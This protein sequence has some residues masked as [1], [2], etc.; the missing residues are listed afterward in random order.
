MIR[1]RRKR[2]SAANIYRSCIRHGNCPPDVKNKIENNT[3]ADKILRYGSGAVYF[4]SLGIGT[5]AATAGV[6]IGAGAAGTFRPTGPIDAVGPSDVIPVDV[7]RPGPVAPAEPGL[8]APTDPSVFEPV[9]SNEIEL[10]DFSVPGKEDIP[11]LPIPPRKIPEPFVP[12]DPLYVDNTVEPEI[13]V[14]GGSEYED[15]GPRVVPQPGRTPAAAD[16]V[17]RT[18]YSNPAFEVSVHTDTSIGEFSSGDSIVVYGGGGRNV[19]EMIPMVEFMRPAPRPRQLEEETEF[20]T[21]T[22]EPPPEVRAGARPRA[23]G[24]PRRPALTNRR[25]FEQVPV[26]DPAFLSRPASLVT[27]ENPAYEED[28]TIMFENDVDDVLQ[29]PHPDFRDVVRLGRPEVTRLPSGTIR[30]SR[31]GERATISTRS[32]AVIGARTHFYRDLSSITED[33]PLTVFGEMAGEGAI[34]Q[35]LAETGFSETPPVFVDPDLEVI[36]VDDPSG[37]VPDE[38]LL[39]EIED[40]GS[41]AQLI[42]TQEET[43]I[44]EGPM[45]IMPEFLRPP[46]VFPEGAASGGVHV[47]YP[48]SNDGVPPV[49]PRVRPFIVLDFDSQDY[50]LHPS[51]FPKRKRRRKQIFVY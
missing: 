9:D 4:G 44:G 50:V 41:N 34:S 48:E 39:D 14:T 28:I 7:L 22:P 19:G 35:P 21:S 42:V 49:N 8:V 5:G 45:S 23:R 1:R 17:S 43:P 32:G 47:W 18:Q 11:L 36:R 40:V 51:L 33:I 20:L 26:S 25:R 24:R 38:D 16:R 27:F 12:G 46:F 15:I 6:R 31:L 3:L 29:A 13:S 30:V 2:D 37:P 10:P